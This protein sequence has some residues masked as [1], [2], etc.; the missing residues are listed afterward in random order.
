[1][2]E[3]QVYWSLEPPLADRVEIALANLTALTANVHRD[4]KR[5][6]KP[7][8]AA[9][10]M[11]KWDRGEPKKASPEVAKNAMLSAFGDRVKFKPRKRRKSV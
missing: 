4:P 9:D 3:W 2:I 11:P 10:F 7:F 5:R 1:M 8:T 6:Q